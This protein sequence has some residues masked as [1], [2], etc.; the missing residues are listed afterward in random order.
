MENSYISEFR[1]S[2]VILDTIDYYLSDHR[3]VIV[4]FRFFADYLVI[5]ISYGPNVSTRFRVSRSIAFDVIYSITSHSGY[6]HL[7]FHIL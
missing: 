6:S 1:D 5:V 2:S 4:C 7:N 3:S